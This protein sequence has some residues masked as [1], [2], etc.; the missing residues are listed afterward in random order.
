MRYKNQILRMNGKQYVQIS[1]MAAKK[2]FD[3]GGTIL[4]Q[5]S[6]MIFDGVWQCPFETNKKSDFFINSISSDEKT[7]ELF[8]GY[9]TNCEKIIPLSTWKRS[10]LKVYL[11]K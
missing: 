6:N 2:L 5:S 10:I 4:L 11:M 7:N 8:A 3:N 1:K 9:A